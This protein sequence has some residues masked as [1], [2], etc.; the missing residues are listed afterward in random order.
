MLVTDNDH[1][2]LSTL[3]CVADGAD[4]PDVVV[5]SIATLLGTSR[6]TAGHAVYDPGIDTAASDDACTRWSVWVAT[7]HL[8]AHVDLE[9]MSPGYDATEEQDV[10]TWEISLP[11]MIV[12]AGWVRPLR[13]I[14]SLHIDAPAVALELFDR[15]DGSSTLVV[16][17]ITV[18][19]RDDHAAGARRVIR[20][21]N[22][23]MGG[24]VRRCAATRT[25]GGLE[26]RTD[27]RQRIAGWWS[28]TWSRRGCL[29]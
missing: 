21:E 28:H 6:G 29:C 9:I 27:P 18:G 24:S 2:E 11:K 8:L 23:G 17:S 7:A 3:C 1:V 13:S 12:H 16:P 10:E 19:F 4:A 25:S 5:R 26:P 15:V 20:P 22:G 14:D